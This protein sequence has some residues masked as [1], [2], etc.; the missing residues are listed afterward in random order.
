MK[1]EEFEKVME[2]HLQG[3]LGSPGEEALERHLESCRECREKLDRLL[4][5]SEKS[6]LPPGGVRETETGGGQRPPGPGLDQE[7]QRKI[8]R[9]ARWKNRLSMVF[10]VIVFLVVA[11]VLGT[12]LSSYYYTG[13]G[14]NSPVYQAQRT[15][16]LLTEFSIPNVT[17][18]LSL[19]NSGMVVR[20]GWGHSDLEIKPYF[21][22]LGDYALEKQVGKEK[23]TIGYLGLNHIGGLTSTSWQW[24]DASH[25]VKLC[26]FYPGSPGTGTPPGEVTL[27][28]EGA[29]Q[30]EGP[31]PGEGVPP[32]SGLEFFGKEAWEALDM[33]PEGTVAEMAVSF[34]D[35]YSLEQVK[36]QLA[37]Y[38]LEIVWYAVST[39]LEQEE[40]HRPLSAFMGA[41]GFPDLSRNMLQHYSQ[42]GTG[43]TA[44]REEYFLDS[45]AYLLEREGLAQQVY[46]GPS[47]SLRLQERYDYLQEN[48]VQVYGV[49]VT[50]PVKELLKLRELESAHSPALGE[51]QLWNWFHRSFRGT[52]Y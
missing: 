7:E 6:T 11:Q 14:E 49:V 27:P 48:G 44:L 13:R 52:M 40:P 50:G 30:G 29:L 12:M 46:R 23:I 24:K 33:M 43:D 22:A 9:R 31:P 26:F 25:D 18:P 39:G 8:F 51:V 1:C 38:D 2:S 20:A 4:E 19:G 42:V 10:Y 35:L 15:A 36:D 45:M 28:G 47:P 41:W 3:K 16:V 34:R 5:E 37:G 32:A 17:M 21:V